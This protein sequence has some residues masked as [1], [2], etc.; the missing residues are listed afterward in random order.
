MQ[1]ST[2]AE[3]EKSF[4]N[5][6]VKQETNSTDIEKASIDEKYTNPNML[7]YDFTEQKIRL[8][9]MKDK[10]KLRKK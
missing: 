5:T 1:F 8:F 4:F 3:T 9:N 2:V 10:H 6:I 7:H